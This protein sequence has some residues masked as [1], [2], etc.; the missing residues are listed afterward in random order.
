MDT[1]EKILPLNSLDAVLRTG[2]WVIAVGQFDPL[3]AA[4]AKR[5]H[6]LHTDG[7]KLLAIVLE[8]RQALLPA[9]ARAALIAAL[10]SVDAV[11][12]AEPELWRAAIP[13]N[14]QLR[15]VDDA[16]AEQLRSADFVRYVLARQAAASEGASSQ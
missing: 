3:T 13:T 11:T 6:A 7:S 10:R 16:A 12:I 1:R 4:Q 9:S 15:V 8:T 2:N 14:A 5:L